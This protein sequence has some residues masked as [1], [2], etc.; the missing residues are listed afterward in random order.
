MIRQRASD[1]APVVRAS[2]TELPFA[3]ATFDA[4][5]AILTVHHWPNRRKGLEELAR[6]ARTRVVVLTWDPSAPAF[7]LVEDYFPELIAD[8][9]TIFPTLEELR[10][11]LGRL[12]VSHIP[13]PH[14]CTDGFLGAYW[15]RPEAYLEPSVR[16]AISG[17]AK[18]RS[19]EQGL[20]RL[21]DDLSSG[22]WHRRH[23]ALL[24]ADTLDLGYRLV[25]G[26]ALATAATSPHNLRSGRANP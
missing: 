19:P 18:L 10:R 21:R 14:D 2:A 17:F 24:S 13:I 20:E 15:R 25:V 9:R 22:E 1:A 7:W 23:G 5:L 12:T 8:A 6:V 11:D 16:S 4:S 26:G 3:D